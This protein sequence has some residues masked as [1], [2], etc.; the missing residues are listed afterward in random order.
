RHTRSLCH[1]SSDVCSA[2]LRYSATRFN[3]FFGFA[4]NGCIDQDHVLLFWSWIEEVARLPLV[5]DS[6]SR[7]R[8]SFIAP[9][10]H[11]K[12]LLLL[13]TIGTSVFFELTRAKPSQ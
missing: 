4:Q 7:Q 11:T 1:W 2:D 10:R 8:D 6:I 5:S 3:Q 9:A 12:L 13:I